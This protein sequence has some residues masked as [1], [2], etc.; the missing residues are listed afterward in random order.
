I[1]GLMHIDKVNTAKDQEF[2]ALVDFLFEP[3]PPL[4]RRLLDRRPFKSFEHLIDVA[5]E[6]INAMSIE[7]KLVVI[8]AHPQIGASNLSAQ[9][10]VEQG[11]EQDPQ[12]LE[13]LRILNKQ[14]L[15]KFGF[16][17]VEFVNGRSKSEMIPVIEA[18]LLN[19]KAQELETGLKAMILIARDRLRK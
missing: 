11:L 5:E 3:A 4:A 7:D 15:D 9:S 13:R 12:V 2:N 1:C 8:G 18:R 16:I 10:R 6:E 17:F 19:T 14:Y